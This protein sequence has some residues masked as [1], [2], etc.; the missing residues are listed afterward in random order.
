[1][2]GAISNLKVAITVLSGHNS[3]AAS[4]LQVHTGQV[5]A[6]AAKLAYTMATHDDMLRDVLSPMD[7]RV[8]S[9]FIQAPQDYFDAEPTFKQSY[10][11]QSGAIFGVLNQMKETFETNLATSQKE[12]TI[13]QKSYEEL[14]DAKEGEIASGKKMIS[15]KT[16]E[17]G[18][19]D[20]KNADAQ[21]DLADTKKTLSA[22]QA[23][24]ASLKEQCSLIDAEFAERTKT[25]Q[26]E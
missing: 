17:L 8:V 11:P 12:E 20:E 4:M 7:K 25:R 10:A 14:K 16:T 22:D 1:M 9:A 13:G 18:N 21:E 3:A 6:V 19:T 2:L 5:D 23:F 26:P 24:L 15:K